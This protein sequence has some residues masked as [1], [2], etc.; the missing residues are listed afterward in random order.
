MGDDHE[1]GRDG[2][3]PLF[4]DDWLLRLLPELRS[5]GVRAGAFLLLSGAETPREVVVPRPWGGGMLLVV[6][7]LLNPPAPRGASLRQQPNHRH[8]HPRTMQDR[9]RCVS[10]FF[11]EAECFIRG[12]LCEKET[13]RPG[14]Q[15]RLCHP[16]PPLHLSL[17]LRRHATTRTRTR[18]IHGDE[19]VEAAEQNRCS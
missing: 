7:T 18:S 14:R 3:S 4:P 6:A 17:A 1:A 12:K 5:A 11:E 9:L 8:P 2:P 15:P 10:L 13:E 16:P 19:K